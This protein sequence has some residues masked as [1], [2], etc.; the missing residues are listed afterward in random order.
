VIIGAVG[1]QGFDAASQVP[2]QDLIRRRLA[3][4]N[5]AG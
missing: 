2:V 3:L 1:G 5:D 4:L